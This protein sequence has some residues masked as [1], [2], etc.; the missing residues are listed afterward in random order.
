MSVC[1]GRELGEGILPIVDLINQGLRLTEESIV[2][3]QLNLDAGKKCFEQSDYA[4]AN[5]Y[6]KNALSLLPNDHWE[7][8]YNL[9]LEIHYLSA[10][11]A[12]SCG[13]GENARETVRLILKEACCI[14]DKVDAYF[15]LVNI[16]QAREG[17]FKSECYQQGCGC[18]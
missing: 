7:S 12:H 16:Y 18:C 2:I 9:A 1:K 3:A 13:N 14:E 11:S 15:L 10:K 8:E 6:L 17:K 4:T 5:A